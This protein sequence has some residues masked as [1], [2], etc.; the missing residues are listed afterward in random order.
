MITKMLC[1]LKDGD[2]E[3][4]LSRDVGIS[5]VL[6]VVN[7]IVMEVENK[8]DEALYAYTE[9][10]EGAILDDLQVSEE[11]I[12]AAYDLVD[13]RLMDALSEA[14]DNI[15]QFHN[16]QKEH[17]LWMT[18]IAPGVSVGQK[19]VPLDS[20]GAYVPGGRASYPSSA[21]MNI[22]PAKV[23][24][25]SRVI[26]CT[27]PKADGSITPLTLVAAD[28]AGADEIYKIGGAQ[29]I[30]AMALGTESLDRVQ[31][32][33]GPGNVYVTA[34]K[35]LMRGSVEI[36][37][38][39]GPSE[40]LILAD[41]TADPGVIAADMI[42]QGEH[43]PRS[44]SVLVSLDDLL[45]S[46]VIEELSI[47]GALAARREIVEQSLQHSAVLVANDIDEAVDFCNAFAPEHLEIITK[48]PMDV[49]RSIH[50]AGSVFLG[51]YTP[52]AAGDYASGTNHVLPTSGYARTFSGLNVDHF[53][54]KISV[55]MITDEGLL[56]L[57]DTIITLAEAE[58]LKAHAESVRR[59]LEPNV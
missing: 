40:V 44:I 46:A 37:F 56:G 11:E 26:V 29:A 42:A 55:Q 39:A 18:E 48:D 50:N 30:A 6:S 51:K 7:E 53:T 35:M 41:R 36:D 43:D 57:E 45:A 2:L 5:E 24:G 4:L 58:G 32:I 22:I 19:V 27:P 12:D 8:G 15:F 17:D 33:V 20:V 10:F 9:K 3:L 23:A 21:L 49:L 34:A 14:K 13:D 31:K 28:M 52:V 1:E 47:Q 59:R 16:Q 25:V 38:P 54:K